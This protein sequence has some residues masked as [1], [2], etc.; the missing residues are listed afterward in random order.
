LERRADEK[1]EYA[2]EK[3]ARQPW[4]ICVLKRREDEFGV[5]FCAEDVLD[6]GD[7]KGEGGGV[8][9]SG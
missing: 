2:S 8:Q 9:S 5:G 6:V 7:G 4:R 1:Q 3:H